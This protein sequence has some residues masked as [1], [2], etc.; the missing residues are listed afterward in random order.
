MTVHMCNISCFPY[1]LLI[2]VILVILRNDCTWQ[3]L[4]LLGTLK[5]QSSE[6]GEGHFRIY[7]TP[8]IGHALLPGVQRVQCWP[9]KKNALPRLQPAGLCH[10]TTLSAELV[11]ILCQLLSFTYCTNTPIALVPQIQ[12][13]MPHA[14]LFFLTIITHDYAIVSNDA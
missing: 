13:A 11:E 2:C 4:E 12:Q 9:F 1:W 3:V 5:V 7:G 10:L 14:P 6:K 8:T